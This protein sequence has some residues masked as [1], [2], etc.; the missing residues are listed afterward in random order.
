MCECHALVVVRIE[1]VELRELRAAQERDVLAHILHAGV[2]GVVEGDLPR[3][4]PLGRHQDDAVRAA[5]SID[6]R[7]RCIL[8]NVHGFDIAGIDLVQVGADDAVHHY[9][10]LVARLQ[11]VAAAH[12]D[13]YRIRAR[14]RVGRLDLHA[15]HEPRDGLIDPGH[16]DLRDI[17]AGHRADRARQVLPELRAVA[18]HH[19]LV[20]RD[21]RTRQREVGA[22]LFSPD[23]R[24]RLL[25]RRIPDPRRAE[26]VGP[27]GHS[28][29][30]IAA[31]RSGHRAEVGPDRHDADP[32][33]RHPRLSPHRA[34]DLARGG[35][36]VRRRRG[37]R[38]NAD[39]KGDR[40][41]HGGLLRRGGRPVWDGGRA[42]RASW[43]DAREQ[44]L[45]RVLN[46]AGVDSPTPRQEIRHRQ[47]LT[48]PETRPRILFVYRTNSPQPDGGG[49]ANRSGMS[50]P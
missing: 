1:H 3:P 32:F 48:A 9:K 38:R 40:R 45:L 37:Q 25:P 43:S 18:H 20:Q 39:Q 12:T 15:G 17:L 4:A 50:S 13:A 8:Q 30:H 21:R 35:L 42:A 47:L 2:A 24:D 16:G 46:S 6:R 22:R 7:R 28:H 26:L 11:G 41:S 10:W 14:C 29:N 19:H 31:V 44:H 23:D 27:R 34:L 5:R 49:G 33:Q 36:G